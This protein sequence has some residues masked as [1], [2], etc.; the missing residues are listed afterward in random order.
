MP[1]G[2]TNAPAVFQRLMNDIFRE[3]LD[4]F[5]VVYLD[6]ILIY[7][8]SMI[9]H[10][11]HV[12]IVLQILRDNHLYCEYSKCVFHTTETEFLGFII[13][14]GGFHHFNWGVEDG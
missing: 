9:D 14:T 3:Y 6:D 13:S 11:K 10:V 2:L 7:S 8:N 4:V 12:K 5:V 1:F